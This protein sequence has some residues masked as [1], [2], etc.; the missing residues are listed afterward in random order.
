MSA[1]YRWTCGECGDTFEATGV[2]GD[3]KIMRWRAEHKEEHRYE[4]MSSAERKEYVLQ[5]MQRTLDSSA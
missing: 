4:K 5:K 2:V 3:L 1:T